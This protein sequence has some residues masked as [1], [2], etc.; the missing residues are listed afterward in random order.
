MEQR[1]SIESLNV[2]GDSNEYGSGFDDAELS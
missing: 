2:S 1:V